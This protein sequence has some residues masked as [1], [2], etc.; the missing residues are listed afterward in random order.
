MEHKDVRAVLFSKS[1]YSPSRPFSSTRD[2]NESNDEFDK[3]CWRE[4]VHTAPDGKT[5]V[6]PCMAFKKALEDAASYKGEK[7]QGKG[8]ARYGKHFAAGVMMS[9]DVV[10]PLK[11]DDV[12]HKSF[13]CHADGKRTCGT[14]VWRR[15]PDIP[16]WEGEIM[17]TIID[18]IIT[19][20]VFVKTLEAAGLFIGIGRFRPQNK[21]FYG[22]FGIKELH[23]PK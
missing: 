8:G 14:R 18:P 7:V 15:F 6:I 10:L 23:W 1:P 12:Q 16:T 3:R 22:R 5:V 19:K 9:G 13:Y 17:F 20:D 2:A 11:V 4:H 21:G